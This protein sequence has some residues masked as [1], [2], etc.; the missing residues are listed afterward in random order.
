MVNIAG[1]I[2]VGGSVDETVDLRT[3]AMSADQ[4]EDVGGC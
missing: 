4:C 3:K 2:N 1:T